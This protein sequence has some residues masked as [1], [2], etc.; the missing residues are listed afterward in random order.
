MNMRLEDI[1]EALSAWQGEGAADG[2]VAILLTGELLTGE[3]GKTC[4]SYFGRKYEVSSTL[5]L[6]VARNSQFREAIFIGIQSILEVI[7][8]MLES[9]DDTTEEHYDTKR[10]ARP[11]QIKHD[12]L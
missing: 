9:E 7:G 12:T 4:V 5:G 11:N 10:V 6:V 2:R 8:Q 1:N 3:G